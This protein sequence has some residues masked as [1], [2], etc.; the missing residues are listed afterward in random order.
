M[1]QRKSTRHPAAPKAA[2][3]P[4][5]A[6]LGLGKGESPTG[7]A[8]EKVAGAQRGGVASRLK[9]RV[10]QHAS[11][12]Q[13]HVFNIFHDATFPARSARTRSNPAG[14]Q[15]WQRHFGNGDE[16]S[17]DR[18]ADGQDT[19]SDSGGALGS[20]GGGRFDTGQIPPTTGSGRLNQSAKLMRMQASS[21]LRLVL[22]IS[23]PLPCHLRNRKASWRS[24][25]M[26]DIMN[27]H[28]INWNGGGVGQFG[29]YVLPIRAKVAPGDGAI[30][31]LFDGVTVFD[32]DAA[33]LPVPNGCGGN[34]QFFRQC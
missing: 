15:L 21:L 6:C 30:S 8:V 26:I 3:L 28:V 4:K 13:P 17:R 10:P 22:R 14:L 11:E 7:T 32:G 2:P 25:F 19:D 27:F 5:C 1:T 12:R 23:S 20:S 31:C 16:E 24:G 29:P 33:R 18:Y 34:P 9:L